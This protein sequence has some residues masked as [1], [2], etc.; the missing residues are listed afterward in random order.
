[1]ALW[2]LESGKQLQVFKGHS[3]WVTSVSFFPDGRHLISGSHDRMALVSAV[4]AANAQAV[5]IVLRQAVNV[6]ALRLVIIRVADIGHAHHR[7]FP[8]LVLNSEAPLSRSGY[9][10][11]LCHRRYSGW[12]IRYRRRLAAVHQGDDLPGQAGAAI[13]PAELTLASFAYLRLPLA[14]SNASH[15]TPSGSPA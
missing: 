6:A 15:T 1:M 10:V 4:A 12:K 7:V 2:D 8:Q 11:L 3:E 13:A 14:V 9:F 5:W